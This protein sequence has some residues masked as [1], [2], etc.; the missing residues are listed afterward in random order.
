MS[1]N[2]VRL[3]VQMKG[4]AEPRTITVTNPAMV[5]WDF[6]RQKFNWPKHDQA[7]TLYATYLAWATLVDLGEYPAETP[8]AVKGGKATPSFAQF[9]D[10]DCLH[11]DD[12]DEEVET[13]DPTLTAPEPE[14]VS[15]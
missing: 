11:L 6:D 8:P 10:E 14:P 12:A 7:P 5:R 13:E 15:P 2:R 4:D 3:H 9:R 1:I